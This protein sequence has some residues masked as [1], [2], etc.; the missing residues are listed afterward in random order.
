MVPVR[1]N[2]DELLPSE[3]ETAQARESK[4]VLSTYARRTKP[5]QLEV[6][7]AERR[8]VISLP[9]GAVSLLMD[10][11]A[12]MAEGNAVTLMPMHAELT[13]QQAADILNVSR[14]YLVKLLDGGTIGHRRVGTHRRVLLRE[15]LAYKRRVDEERKSALDEL[16]RQAQEL[17]MGY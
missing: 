11:L 14:P 4:R 13:T 3:Q 9:A 10:L 16:V 12:E 5:L 2:I 1:K 8:E 6:R 17:D 15:V 7:E